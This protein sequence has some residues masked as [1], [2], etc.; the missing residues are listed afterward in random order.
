MKSD[1]E[2]TCPHEVSNWTNDNYATVTCVVASTRPTTR[3]SVEC[4]QYGF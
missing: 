4:L 2:T 3:P 1:L